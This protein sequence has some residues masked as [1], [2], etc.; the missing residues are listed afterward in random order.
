MQNHHLP[1]GQVQ[2]LVRRLL[3]WQHPD[4]GFLLIDDDQGPRYQRRIVLTQRRGHQ[5][6]H[7]FRQHVLAANLQYAWSGRMGQGQHGAKIQVVGEDD[8]AVGQRPGHDYR[9]VGA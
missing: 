7:I 9:I 1:S 2:R 8:V 6:C 5:W 4:A 3:Q